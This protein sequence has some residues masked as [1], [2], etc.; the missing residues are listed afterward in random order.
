MNAGG[1]GGERGV[2]GAVRF[3]VRVAIPE[4]SDGGHARDYARL[5]TD[6]TRA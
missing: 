2:E 3:E 6:R 5:A 1:E 4:E